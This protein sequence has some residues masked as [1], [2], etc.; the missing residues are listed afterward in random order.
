MRQQKS[1]LLRLWNDSKDNKMW[2]GTVLNVQTKEQEHFANLKD[3]RDFIDEVLSK[4]ASIQ[5]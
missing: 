2:R 5:G 3:L 1:Y 4:E